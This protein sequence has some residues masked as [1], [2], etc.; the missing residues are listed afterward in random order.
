MEISQWKNW[1]HL[2]CY[3]V[4]LLTAP[5]CENNNNAQGRSVGM[6][7]ITPLTHVHDRGL[8]KKNKKKLAR[9]FNFTFCYIDDVLSV[10]N[11]RPHC[12]FRGV[13]QGMKQTWLFLWYPVFQAQ[14]D[15]CDQRNRQKFISLSLCSKLF[16]RNGFKYKIQYY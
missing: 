10:Y 4:S 11:S 5:H 14:W 12:E 8:L 2:F 16:K 3:K 15:R 9:S 13:G 7:R 6:P 1:N